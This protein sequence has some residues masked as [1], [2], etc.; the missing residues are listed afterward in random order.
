MDRTLA[1]PDAP[2]I[3]AK[4]PSRPIKEFLKAAQFFWSASSCPSRPMSFP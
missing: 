2:V 1:A 4:L 3:K